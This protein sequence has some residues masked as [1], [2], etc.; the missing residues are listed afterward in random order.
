AV[1]EVAT[2]GAAPAAKDAPVRSPK[3]APQ[4]NRTA[5]MREAIVVVAGQRN[6][7]GFS[8]PQVA[9]QLRATGHKHTE[10]F[11]QTYQNETYQMQKRGEL[12]I[13]QK[14]VRGERP[15]PTIYAKPDIKPEVNSI[16]AVAVNAQEE[17]VP[18]APA[19]P[20]SELIPIP[21]PPPPSAPIIA[22]AELLPGPTSGAQFVDH[23]VYLKNRAI[24]DVEAISRV[25]GIIEREAAR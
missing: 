6:G 5:V 20:S 3:P 21:C 10:E 22:T 7:E 2:A 4:I 23:L 13:L 9:E 18:A 8:W 17:K 1:Y 25:L 14:A 24:S 15:M 12:Q 11:K 16:A 19:H